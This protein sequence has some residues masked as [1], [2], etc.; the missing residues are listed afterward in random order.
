MRHSTRL[1]T[2]IPHPE[3]Y[4]N[5]Q[6][7]A[8][9]HVAALTRSDV[10]AERIFA[11]ASPYNWN[12]VL[13]AFREL[14]PGRKFIDDVPGLWDDLTT[15]EPAKRAEALLVDMGRPGFTPLAQSLRETFEGA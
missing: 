13:G 14:F 6:D 1:S 4:V 12:N 7:N 3:W 5:V 11:C 9:L 15:C 2:D 10:A 8:R